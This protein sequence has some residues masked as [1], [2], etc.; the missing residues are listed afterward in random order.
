MIFRKKISKQCAYC[1]KCVKLDEDAYLCRRKG[2]VLPTGKC[3]RFAYDPLKRIPSKPKAL[4]VRK[5]DDDDF[6]L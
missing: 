6:S 2:M 3:W 4:D 1:Q 5:Y